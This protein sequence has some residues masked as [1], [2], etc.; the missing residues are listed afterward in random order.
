MEKIKFY[1]VIMLMIGCDAS[2]TIKQGESHIT[3]N[4]SP[5]KD[6]S[7]LLSSFIDSIAFIKLETNEIEIV[8]NISKVQ[9]FGDTIYILDRDRNAILL[10]NINGSY[11]TK[12]QNV[13]RGPGEFLQLVDF[14]VNKHGVFL[15]DYPSKIIQYSHKNE[16]LREFY[17][18]NAYTFGFTYFEDLFWFSNEKGSEYEKFHFTV[19]N[20]DGNNI[21]NFVKKNFLEKEF[22]WHLG[23]EFNKH[24]TILYIS[25]L[26]DN[27]IYSVNGN[28]VELV[29]TLNFE[30]YSFP[31]N[32]NIFSKNVYSQDFKYAIKQRFWVSDKYLITDFIFNGERKFVVFEKD[33]KNIQYG[34]VEN[35]FFPGYRFL[36]FWNGR[37]TLIEVIDAITIIEF[38]PFLKNKVS[39]LVPLSAED[40]PI[41]ILYFLKT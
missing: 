29:Y 9:L 41:L 23:G 39:A 13:G 33:N 32:Q 37:N 10:Y 26:F 31:D 40:N 30:R 17:L 4:I 6:D 3:L 24:D 12:I 20:Q 34:F 19:I 14:E 11:I 22:S 2:H 7:F 27:R 36:P 5:Q 35:D 38:F 21:G 15:L 16:Y 18:D 25:P 8:G 1:L 28:D